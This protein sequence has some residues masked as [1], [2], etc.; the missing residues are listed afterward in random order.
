MYNKSCVIRTS[1]GMYQP[2]SGPPPR[3]PLV[4]ASLTLTGHLTAIPFGVNEFV[5][6]APDP[7]EKSFSALASYGYERHGLGG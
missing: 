6:R 1:G 4:H 5:L 7:G 3:R 2:L